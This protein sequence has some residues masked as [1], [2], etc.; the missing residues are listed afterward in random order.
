FFLKNYGLIKGKGEGRFPARRVLIFLSPPTLRLETPSNGA[1]KRDRFSFDWVAVW[2]YRRAVD[3]AEVGGRLLLV[4]AVDAI[5]EH[6]T[7]RLSVFSTLE[8]RNRVVELKACWVCGK[9]SAH[10]AAWVFGPDAQAAFLQRPTG[11]SFAGVVALGLGCERSIVGAHDAASVIHRLN[12]HITHQ[13]ALYNSIS[14]R[15]DP[16]R[17]VGR[18]DDTQLGISERRILNLNAINKNAAQATTIAQGVN[19]RLSEVLDLVRRLSRMQILINRTQQVAGLTDSVCEL[20]RRAAL[21][22]GLAHVVCLFEQRM[23]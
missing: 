4:A 14:A 1:S 10:C 2:P 6:L 23:P 15:L 7:V 5:A 11:Y 3:V 18:Y 12:A 13:D 16:E 20:H 19:M 17:P 22:N 8:Q 21:L 9:P